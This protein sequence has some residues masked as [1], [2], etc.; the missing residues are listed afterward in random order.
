MNQSLKNRFIIGI[1]ILALLLSIVSCDKNATE[2]GK[3]TPPPLP[4]AESMQMN[5]S[6]FDSQPNNLLAKAALSKNNFLAAFGRVFIINT[7]VRVAAIVPT[8]IFVAAASDKQPE[9]QED[10]KFHWIYTVTNQSETFVADLA[11]WIDTPASEIVWEMYV[12]STT[13]NPILNKFLW[14]EG[15]VKIGNKEGWWLFYDDKSP[16]SPIDVL[17]IDWEV[18]DNEHGHLKLTNVHQA[19]PDLGDT[20]TYIKNNKENFLYF[21][22]ASKNEDN[23]IFWNTQTGAGYIQWFDYEKGVRSYWD[24][25]QN[26]IPAPPM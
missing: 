23:T 24:E 22:D 15:R 4:P 1:S 6:L 17:K 7:V 26:D 19:S 5:L 12:S 11:G 18:P 10:G 20:L 16:D 3:N 21:Y 14:Y 13:H 2:P 8:V 25:N 9:L